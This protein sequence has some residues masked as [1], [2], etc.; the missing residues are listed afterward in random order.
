MANQNEAPV[1]A[2]PTSDE[3]IS[4]LG[5]DPSGRKAA[6]RIGQQW[7]DKAGEIWVSDLGVRRDVTVVTWLNGVGQRGS[8]PI[9]VFRNRF[10]LG[11]KAK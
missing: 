5:V 1:A 2:K 8:A 11:G 7:H 10:T 6:V 9:D 3:I 4:S